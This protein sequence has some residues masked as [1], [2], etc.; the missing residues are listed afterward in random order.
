[1]PPRPI[2]SG[3]LWVIS[4]LETKI[5][6]LD[7]SSR[8]TYY[9]ISGS[10]LALQNSGDDAVLYYGHRVAD[11]SW[12]H[13][14]QSLSPPMPES[15]WTSTLGFY[16]FHYLPEFAQLMSIESMIS[17]NHLILCRPLLLPSIFPSIRVFFNESALRIRWPKVFGVS[18]SASALPKWI[19]RIDFL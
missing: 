6:R 19:F 11:Q 9:T 12:H 4:S 10:V 13:D 8:D 5:S 17:S 3:I 7:L 1:M 15:P 14:A 2:E 18:A 16:V